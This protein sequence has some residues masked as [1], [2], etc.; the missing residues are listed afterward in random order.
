[1]NMV[2]R[3]LG[4]AIIT[5]A[6]AVGGYFFIDSIKAADEKNKNQREGDAVKLQ[7]LTRG[8]TIEV[9]PGEFVSKIMNP[10]QIAR[11][12]GE[13]LLTPE[14]AE[15]LKNGGRL[16]ITFV[17]DPIPDPIEVGTPPIEILQE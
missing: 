12:V 3:I 16:R 2:I 7:Q 9:T 15:G 17:P 10:H 8:E 13:G 6:V 4:F 5:L 11:M 14:E 1:M